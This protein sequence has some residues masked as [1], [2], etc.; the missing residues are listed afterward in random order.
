VLFAYF[1]FHA[2]SGNNGLLSYVK[3]KKQLVEQT[4]KLMILK[5]DLEALKLRVKLL[6]SASL[7][8]DLLEERCRAVLNYCFP[9]DTIVKEGTMLHG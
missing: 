5:G 6:S 4:E 1:L 7:D 9:D 8:L 3:I 2:I